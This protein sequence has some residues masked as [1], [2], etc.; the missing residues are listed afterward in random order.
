MHFLYTHLVKVTINQ[1]IDEY[2]PHLKRIDRDYK[3]SFNNISRLIMLDRYSQKDK[4]LKTLANNDLV[5]VLI[6]D[7]FGSISRVIGY[8]QTIN[9]EQKTASVKIEEEYL[10]RIDKSYFMKD[11]INV[12]KVNF[13]DLEKPLEIFFEQI[14]WRVAK[15]LADQE[16][17]DELKKEWREKFYNE[18][19]NLNII[20]A[21]RVLYGAGSQSDVTYFNCFVMPM[22][23][24]SREGIS[25]HRKEV[26]EIMSHGGGVGSNG[27]TLRPKGAIAK[28]V[29]GKSSGAVS[30]LHDLSSLTHLVEQGGSRRG[31]QMIMLA[32]WHP[33]IIE[34]IIS[35]MQRPEIL[36]WIIKN[37]KDDK[38]VKEASKKLKFTPFTNEELLYFQ[39]IVYHKDIFDKKTLQETEEKIK[40]GGKYETINPDFLTGANISITLSNKFM[41]ALKNNEEWHLQFPDLEKL[42]T[43]EKDFY[44]KNWH[45]IAN[46]DD[47]V[48]LGYPVRTHYTLKASVL[49]DLINF[50]ANYSAEPGIFFIDRANEMTNASSYGMKVVAT[51]PCGEQPLAP[52]SVCNLAALNLDS[53]VNHD[54]KEILWEKL[55]NTIKIC[56]RLQDNVID[57]TPY[58]FN[59]NKIQALGER[60]VGLG[61][62]SLHDFLIWSGYRYGSDKGNKIVDRLFHTIARTAYLASTNLAAEKGSFPFL[63]SRNAFINT[64]YM[65]KMDEDV[66]QA[67]IK[68]GIR[69]SHLL[70]VAPTGTTGTLVGNSTGLEPYF[71]FKMYRS[72]RLGQFIEVTANIVDE[73]IKKQGNNNYTID[74]L[75]QNLFVSAQDLTPEEHVKVQ[76][77][78]QRWVDSSISKTVNA[79]KGYTVKQVE[80]IYMS[81]YD[82]GAKGGTVYVDG[83]RS[84]QVLSLDKE[85]DFKQQ[86]TLNNLDEENKTIVTEKEMSEEIIEKSKFRGLRQDREIGFNPGD[87]CP[88]CKEGTIILQ[89]GC[90]TCN[91]CN[92]QLK[93]DI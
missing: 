82:Q 60:R 51:N 86:I 19:K 93:C 54:T 66:R 16:K 87:I 2:F 42:S 30:W 18:I 76:C 20:P 8:V 48:K 92:T 46:I 70:T 38:I 33:D 77:V 7:N 28:S 74:N 68:N 31:A 71:A 11:S 65:L 63:K 53:F 88:Q 83:S 78:I 67:V 43:E 1:N 21:G 9:P 32:D 84:T 56:V 52:Y 44:D 59:K 55:E 34:F 91:N 25:N 12:I 69:N 5:L 6:K 10:E 24:D 62:M 85:D 37:F 73:W 13:I 80:S 61:V 89:A 47:W 39:K 41:Q 49:W 75:P 36:S 15:N 17:T 26:M 58:F 45:N 14:A 29:G 79:P 57:A 50:C 22:I 27:S 81:L 72:G 90:A 35:K 4:T 23:A 40:L 64:G 3:M